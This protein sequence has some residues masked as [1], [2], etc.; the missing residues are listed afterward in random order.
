MRALEDL[1]T[2]IRACRLCAQHLPLGPR[3]VL[4]ASATAKL[5]IVGQAPGTRVHESGIPWNDAS[6]ERLRDWLE[7]APEV[8]YDEARVAIVPMGFCYPGRN[9]KGGDNPPRPE[10][11]P[12]WHQKLL[13]F[14]PEVKLTLL[15]GRYAQKHYLGPAGKNTMTETVR[16]WRETLPRFL[17]TPHPS[18]R[19]TGWLRK[20]PW[21]EAEVV[22]ELR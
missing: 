14:I 17:P 11:A 22:P 13:K 15:V 6:G 20:N 7:M 19:T 4:Q 16:A 10:C 8:F 18:W 12:G 5:L 9:E 21:F 2:E 3:P 1:L